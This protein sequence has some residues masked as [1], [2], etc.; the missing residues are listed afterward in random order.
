MNDSQKILLSIGLIILNNVLGHYF[1]PS[2]I[3]M[4]PILAGII[5]Y[6]LATSSLKIH[7]QILLIVLSLVSNDVLTKLYAGG[8]HDLE[9]A[10]FIN[11]F[12]IVGIVIS[13]IITLSIS[14]A[15]KRSIKVIL[16]WFVVPISVY[17]YLYN[18]DSLGLYYSKNASIS[19]KMS[20]ERGLFLGEL[21]FSDTLVSYKG[22]SV[23][24][25]NGWMERQQIVDHTRLIKKNRI[26]SEVNYIIKV[27]C[28][29][30]PDDMS[31][32]YKSD[33]RNEY[34]STV[35]ALRTTCL[36]VELY[37]YSSV[38]TIPLDFYGL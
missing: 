30:I 5:S 1:P 3:F 6:L 7:I 34:G 9:G 24:L 33:N 21:I 13:T 22:D 32:L 11:L 14:I 16:I 35:S 36:N 12:L 18:Y 15:K 20:K 8:I 38:G 2:S 29:K 27:R 25:L 26:G 23:R 37:F 10:G 28:N 17:I 4:A 31:L 19:A